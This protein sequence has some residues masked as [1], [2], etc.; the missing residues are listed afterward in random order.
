[1]R[2]RR[3]RQFVYPVAENGGSLK[4]PRAAVHLPESNE[5]QTIPT[6]TTGTLQYHMGAY[7]ERP[8]LSLGNLPPGLAKPPERVECLGPDDVVVRERLGGLLRHYERKVA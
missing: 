7:A 4:S 8:H 6:P 5:F 3:R 2:P 1:M